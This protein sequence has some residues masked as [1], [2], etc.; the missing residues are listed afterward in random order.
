[1]TMTV[2]EKEMTYPPSKVSTALKGNKSTCF[3][4][5]KKMDVTHTATEAVMAYCFFIVA[6]YHNGLVTAK[7]LSTLMTPRVPTIANKHK[8]KETTMTGESQSLRLKHTLPTISSAIQNLMY[9]GVT[10]PPLITSVNVKLQ[11]CRNPGRNRS[12]PLRIVIKTSPFDRKHQ[13]P[14]IVVAGVSTKLE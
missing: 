7:Y 13:R 3:K 10:T 5:T 6:L 2:A 12:P 11:R 1:M 4:T 14:S 8:K 9:S